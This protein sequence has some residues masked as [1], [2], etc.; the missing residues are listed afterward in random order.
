MVAPMVLHG[1]CIGAKQI[2]GLEGF[3]L[4]S[5]LTFARAQDGRNYRAS[6]A[7]G[8]L[9]TVFEKT[10][11][12]D[13]EKFQELVLYIADRSAGDENFGATKLNKIL[14]Y[15]DFKA[16]A[17]LGKPISGA[18]Y[19]RLEF[20]PAPKQLKPIEH[21]MIARG[22]VQVVERVH[23]GRKQKRLVPRRDPNLAPFTGE[24]IAIVD[25]VIA[26][27]RD[28]NAT[29]LTDLSHCFR[30]WKHADPGE[31]IPYYTALVASDQTLTPS[32]VADAQ[33]IAGQLG[34]LR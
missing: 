34:L 7:T 19:Q 23:F 14:F 24:E 8:I 11:V 6:Q 12:F 32:E 30:G 16:Y 9:M 15:C 3:Q 13:A 33:Q 18:T 17:L 1:L 29:D 25:E 4:V 27:A 21:E 5:R 22:D 31:E 2:L 28:M 10:P 26:Q 20:G